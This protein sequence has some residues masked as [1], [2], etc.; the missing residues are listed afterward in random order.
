[1]FYWGLFSAADTMASK[2]G[3]HPEPERLWLQLHHKR[4]GGGGEEQEEREENHERRMLEV[5]VRFN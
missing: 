3:Q 5:F 4:E 1:M 2:K